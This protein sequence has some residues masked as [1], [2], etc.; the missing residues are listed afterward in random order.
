[1]EIQNQTNKNENGVSEKEFL[2]MLMAEK[3]YDKQN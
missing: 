1:V 2:D 3:Q